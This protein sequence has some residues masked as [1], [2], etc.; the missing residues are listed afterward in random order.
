M[1]A[2]NYEIHYRIQ[3]VSSRDY[4][5]EMVLRTR[6]RSE[7]LKQTSVQRGIHHAWW[8]Y[9]IP[10]NL[11]VI[12]HCVS[13]KFVWMWFVTKWISLTFLCPILTRPCC[14][15]LCYAKNRWG[16]GGA[17]W[18]I[19]WVCSERKCVLKYL[20][21]KNGQ[22]VIGCTF[23]VCILFLSLRQICCHWLTSGGR[24]RNWV[25]PRGWSTTHFR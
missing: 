11:P 12:D 21:G 2:M 3:L 16:W 24:F 25:F 8:L 19:Y 1:S 15:S 9:W 6:Y 18:T 10:K 22:L 7:I 4:T 23:S 13:G 5:I 20:Q 14:D 17:K